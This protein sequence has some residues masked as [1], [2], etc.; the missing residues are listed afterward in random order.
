V[1]GETERDREAFLPGGEVAAGEGV[2][3][4]P[5]GEAGVLAHSPRLRH[6]HGRVGAA[7]IGRD[8]GP[9][10]EE[11]DALEV[12]RTIARLCGNVV[13]TI[14]RLDGNVPGRQPGIAVSQ[15]RRR[16]CVLERDLAEVRDH[17]FTSSPRRQRRR[18][19]CDKICAA[20]RLMSSSGLAP[21]D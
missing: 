9:G 1:G 19:V 8:A 10:V 3:V 13:W 11:V 12:V 2:T 6:V 4:F 16:L 18:G 15:A 17:G 21:A 14:A 20:A 5:G 7:P